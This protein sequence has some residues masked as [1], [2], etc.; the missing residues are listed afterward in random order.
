MPP[1]HTTQ[2][3][4]PSGRWIATRSYGCRTVARGPTE[5]MGRLRVTPPLPA[6]ACARSV[7]TPQDDRQSSIQP[8]L[9]VGPI[10]E[11]QESSAPGE[12]AALDRARL[13]AERGGA[14]V[15]Q[16][17]LRLQ[18][19]VLFR[20][21]GEPQHIRTRARECDRLEVPVRAF[22]RL[23]QRERRPHA[24]RACGLALGLEED[25]AAPPAQRTRA[26]LSHALRSGQR[27][28][29]NGQRPSGGRW[30]HRSR[31]GALREPTRDS[32]S[33]TTHGLCL[34]L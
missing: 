13:H 34:L 23:A 5:A 14:H 20:R 15:D 16:A 24:H 12:M 30:T 19:V 1:S 2:Q 28:A 18:P 9:P 25:V 7:S 17:L 3:P 6:S 32:F 10:K 31:R 8:L 11:H 29:A 22:P 4:S 26:R 27:A 21:G 33:G